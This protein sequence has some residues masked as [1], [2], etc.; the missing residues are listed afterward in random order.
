MKKYTRRP[1]TIMNTIINIAIIMKV[2]DERIAVARS[3]K[4]PF[5]NHPSGSEL[6]ILHSR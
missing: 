1:K 5:L 2:I 6:K 4:N 3:E